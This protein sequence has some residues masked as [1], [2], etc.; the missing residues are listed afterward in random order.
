[1]TDVENE[2]GPGWVFGQWSTEE[3]IF[4]RESYDSP[5]SSA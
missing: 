5:H 3:S 2:L 1:M 4:L